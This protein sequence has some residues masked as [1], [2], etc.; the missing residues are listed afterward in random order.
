MEGKADGTTNYDNQANQLLAK[1]LKG[2]LLITHGTMDNNVPPSNTLLVV[3]ALI[4]ANKDFDMILYPN[5]R[6]R[7]GDMTNYMTRKRWYYFVTHLLNAKPAK[8]FLL[9]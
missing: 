8:G 2:K 4:K 9:K 6:H 5:K 7:Y 1:D 3:E